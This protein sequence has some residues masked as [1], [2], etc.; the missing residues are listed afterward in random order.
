V[1]WPERYFCCSVTGLDIVLS[2]T[3]WP[4][5]YLCCS[6]MGLDIVLSGTL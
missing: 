6:V 5:K 3:L 4:E 1:L 2:G